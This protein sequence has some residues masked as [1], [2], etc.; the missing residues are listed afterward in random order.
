MLL[1]HELNVV[2][3]QVLNIT[4]IFRNYAFVCTQ[5]IFKN[6]DFKGQFA[7]TI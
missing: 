4:D 5:E 1:V 3:V 7:P 6:N 2:Y